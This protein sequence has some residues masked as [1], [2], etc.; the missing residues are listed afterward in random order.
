[1]GLAVMDLNQ[2]CGARTRRVA[3]GGPALARPCRLLVSGRARS[4]RSRQALRRPGMAN[5]PVY[6]TLQQVYLL[7][8]DW[9]LEQSD[10]DDIDEAERRRITFHLRQLVDAMSP[11]PC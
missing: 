10:A 1:M 3:G 11:T 9:L 6:R 5:E 4:R 8:S 2:I 7:A